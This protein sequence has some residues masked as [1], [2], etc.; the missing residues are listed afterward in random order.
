MNCHLMTVYQL[1]SGVVMS[2]QHQL[3]QIH[4]TSLIVTS[5]LVQ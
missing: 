4:C 3:H 5:G 1:S 2:L